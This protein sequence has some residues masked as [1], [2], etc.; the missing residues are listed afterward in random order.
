MRLQLKSSA[1]ALQLISSSVDLI[2]CGSTYPTL[3]SRIRCVASKHKHSSASHLR[4]SI[5][6]RRIY[7][8]LHSLA[9]YPYICIPWRRILV[10]AFLSVASHSITS[11]LLVS[12]RP[13]AQR[14]TA[15]LG[16]VTTEHHRVQASCMCICMR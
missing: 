5:P 1:T 6:W 9:S 15:A 7:I 12:S 16:A 8:H 10:F 3:W 14:R 13:R 4:I 2:L 11:H